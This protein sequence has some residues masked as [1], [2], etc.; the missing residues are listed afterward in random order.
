MHS[1]LLDNTLKKL[2]DSL[3]IEHLSINVDDFLEMVEISF[4]SIEAE[5]AKHREQHPDLFKNDHIRDA[6]TTLFEG[7]VGEPYSPEKLKE[8][9]RDGE[10]RYSNQV[11]PGYKD[12]KEKK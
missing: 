4:E 11:P 12:R 3:R 5:L 1:Y 7:K 10:E 8:I 9:Y 2:R 6:I